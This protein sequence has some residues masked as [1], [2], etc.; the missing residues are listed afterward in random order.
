MSSPA[1]SRTRWSSDDREILRQATSESAEIVRMAGGRPVPRIFEED[2]EAGFRDLETEVLASLAGKKS[3]VISTGGGL[4]LRAENREMRASA[5][6][7]IW[8]DATRQAILER[9][10]GNA[11]RPLLRGEDLEEKVDR[12]LEA[13]RSLYEQAADLRVETNGLS[14]ADVAYGVAESIRFH[15]AD[16]ENR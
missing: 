6:F 2:G 10:A 4:P 14:V 7:V 5:G 16:R 11:N 12:M 15:F 9:V 8:L 3:L 1:R 13:R